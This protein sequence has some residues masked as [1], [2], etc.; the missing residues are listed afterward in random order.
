MKTLD[1]KTAPHLLFISSF[2]VVEQI[3]FDL[4]HFLKST[5]ESGY[6]G[7]AVVNFALG[8]MKRIKYKNKCWKLWVFLNTV[9]DEW[10]KHDCVWVFIS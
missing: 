5:Y 2:T 10:R 6:D 1:A 7:T 4:W 3:R 8:L 9:R